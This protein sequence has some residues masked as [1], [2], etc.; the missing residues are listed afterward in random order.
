MSSEAVNLAH[1]EE[2]PLISRDELLRR[3][4][5][6]SLTILDVLP[7]ESYK[8]GHI[9]GALSLPAA[10]VEARARTILLDLNREMVVYCASDTCGA[11][12]TAGFMLRALGFAKVRHY[13]GGIAEWRDNNGPIETGAGADGMP[14]QEVSGSNENPSS[15]P[16]RR[17]RLQPLDSDWLD[18]IEG[19]TTARLFL[20]WL[21][22]VLSCGVLYWIDIMV[23]HRGLAE[24]GH[25][26][27][28]NLEGFATAIYF[29]FVTAT[30]L[31]YGDVV[32]LG[33][34]RVLAIV[35][36]V[37]ALLIFGAVVAKLV[38]RRQDK[39][40]RE[41]HELSLDER[42]DRVQTNLHTVF[43]ELQEIM[44]ACEV[45]AANVAQ[46]SAR[47]ESATLVFSGELR[48]VHHLLYQSRRTPDETTLETILIGLDA[49]LRTLS[50]L[51]AC[52]PGGLPRSMTLKRTLG[53]LA[54]LSSEICA[55][56][57]P[58]VYAPAL[59][60]WMDRIHATATAMAV[61]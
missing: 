22:M 37:A 41:I 18:K 2:I 51:L 1:S 54:R 57:V 5:D 35:E 14:A 60:S 48:T 44:T 40:V 61:N 33:G 17:A 29:S 59:G 27:A 49:C 38:S 45:S 13:H 20:I 9:P 26:V 4:R 47:L 50:E 39:L 15:V 31:G 21:A 28:A 34:M 3:L 43:G 16:D 25:P 19:I 11:A 42:L 24:G 32:P 55:D 23:R 10:D 36:A 58:R 53:T 56:C 6:P 12:G 30:S 52:I 46:I 7:L 8:N